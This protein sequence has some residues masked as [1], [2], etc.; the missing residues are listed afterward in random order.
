MDPQYLAL[1]YKINNGVFASPTKMHAFIKKTFKTKTKNH[2]K[3]VNK[4][5]TIELLIDK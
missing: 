4:L 5:S 3:H 1:A 2:S